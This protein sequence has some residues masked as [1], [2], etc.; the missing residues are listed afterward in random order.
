MPKFANQR[1]N[2]PLRKLGANPP[3]TL[4]FLSLPRKVYQVKS[5]SSMPL[6]GVTLLSGATVG[7]GSGGPSGGGLP[8]S[9]PR[10]VMR[11]SSI[12]AAAKSSSSPGP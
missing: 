9:S 1:E 7:R 3:T 6:T 10:A 12:V 5:Y 11:G 8:D 2:L 4:A